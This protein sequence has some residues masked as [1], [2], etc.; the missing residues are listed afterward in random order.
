M[1]LREEFIFTV[2]TYI[3][4]YIYTWMF[5]RCE[6]RSDRYREFRSNKENFVGRMERG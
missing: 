3:Y 6:Q 1:R 5:E 2:Y 4:I